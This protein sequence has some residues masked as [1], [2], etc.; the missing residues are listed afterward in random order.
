M[1]EFHPVTKHI[2]AEVTG[3]DLRKPLAQEEVHILRQGWL[4]HLCCSFAISTSTT[5][6][7]C[8]SRSTSAP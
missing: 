2:G 4:K 3:V 5:S 6:S 7:T 1:I 8:S